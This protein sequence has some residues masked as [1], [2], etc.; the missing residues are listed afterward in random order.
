[1]HVHVQSSSGEA[2]YWMEPGIELVVNCGYNSSELAKV[3]ALIEE[4]ED[5]IRRAWEHHFGR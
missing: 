4:H 1:M 5:E 2:K 3:K